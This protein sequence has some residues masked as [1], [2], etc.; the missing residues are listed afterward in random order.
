MSTLAGI[1]SLFRRHKAAAAAVRRSRPRKSLLVTF[2]GVLFFIVNAVVLLAGLNSETNLLL[3]LFGVGVGAMLLNAVLPLLMLR[4]I[5]VDRVMPEGVVADRPF[6]VAYRVRNLRKRLC[7]WAL[8]ITETPSNEP[9]A[10][11]PT[12]F[13]PCLAPGSEQRIEVFGRCLR[14]ARVPLQGIRLVSRF[15]FG[16]LACVVDY[17]APGELTVYP[18]IGRLRHDPWKAGTP[19]PS[20]TTRRSRERENPEEFVGVREFREGD[21]YRWI[22][23]RRSAHTGDLVVREMIPLRQTRL[24]LVLDPWPHAEHAGRSDARPAEISLEAEQVISA[25]AT[26]ICESLERGH[27]VGLICRAAEPVVIAPASGKAHRQRMLRELAA[28]QAG[29]HTPL[30]ELVS[31]AHFATGWNVRS[32]I[33]CGAHLKEHEY[34]ARAIGSRSEATL[35]MTPADVQFSSLFDLGTVCDPPRRQAAG[36]RAS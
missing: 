21:N 35:L 33:L 3:L 5:E 34:V 1:G 25:A 6:V 10:R 11:F 19:G 14:R 36:R 28:V 7:S 29:A 15:P 27:R 13:I 17:A 4:R 23:W 26:A 8:T 22:H 2:S 24:I 32:V 31:R 9:M 20:Q 16:L 18:P 30:G 12:A